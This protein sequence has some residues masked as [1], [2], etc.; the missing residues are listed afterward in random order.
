MEHSPGQIERHGEGTHYSRDGLIYSGRWENG[1]MN[2]E[3]SVT[4]FRYHRCMCVCIG[5][6]RSGQGTKDSACIKVQVNASY[7]HNSLWGFCC[8][9]VYMYIR[10]LPA[11]P[12]CEG[13][14]LSLSSVRVD[15]NGHLIFNTYCR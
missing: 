12:G 2:G 3:G 15:D 10:K 6:S 4:E 11:T 14:S 9:C 8:T 7:C 5:K 13:L 1:K